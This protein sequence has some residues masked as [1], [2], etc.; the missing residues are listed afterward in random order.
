LRQEEP[1]PRTVEVVEPVGPVPEDDGTEETTIRYLKR[2]RSFWVKRDDN[3]P[4]KP[5]V[6]VYLNGIKS[7]DDEVMKRLANFKHLTTLSF[8]A[9]KIT[10]ESLKEIAVHKNLTYL[11]L[12]STLVDDEGMK[13]ISKLK[14]LTQLV[15]IGP[16]VTDE[17]IREI[18]KLANLTHLDIYGAPV[19]P[20]AFKELAGLKKLRYLN[21]D[22]QKL[23]DRTLQVLHEANLLHALG[24]ASKEYY[25]EPRWA[26]VV[27]LDLT[28]TPVTDEGL[29]VIANYKDLIWLSLTRTKVTDEGVMELQK[30][31]PKCTIHR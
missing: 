19:S 29:K 28:N 21:I 22:E 2:Y 24:K 12:S 7:L 25:G 9:T 20:E 30:A 16:R 6:A 15:M 18:G 10:N 13:E 17:G 23:T 31:L 26:H 11:D 5:V 27:G 1:R 4:E 8:D 14:N 3:K